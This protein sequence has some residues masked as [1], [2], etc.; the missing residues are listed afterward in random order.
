MKNRE[1]NANEMEK[2]SG[3]D[4]VVVQDCQVNNSNYTNNGSVPCG[5]AIYSANPAGISDSVFVNNKD[6]SGSLAVNFDPRNPTGNSFITNNMPASGE[7]VYI[8]KK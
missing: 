7:A 2:A 4:A 1:L 6:T 5:E 3:G 8:P